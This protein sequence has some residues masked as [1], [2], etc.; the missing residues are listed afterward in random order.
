MPAD[1]SQKALAE[2]VSEAQETIDALGHGLMQLEAGGHEDPD[3][4]V[5]NGVFR[6][7]HTLKGLSSMSGVER[8]TRLA[9]ALEDLLDEVR[10][11]RRRLDRPALDLLLEAP[12][13]LSRIVAEEASG[14]APASTD[15]AARLTDRLRAGEA[16]PPARAADSLATVALGPEVLG[17]LTE[18]EEHRLR[19]NL[20]KGLGLH[21]VKVSFDLDGFDRELAALNGRLKRLGEVVSTLPS[22]DLRDPQ[23]IAFELL[24]ASKEPVDAIRR[25]A[26]PAAAVEAVPRV[27]AP[28]PAPRAD[29]P[30]RAGG[31]LS[32]A[33][34]A[35]SDDAASLRSASQAVRVDIHEL[36][37][38]MNAVGELVLVK[39]SLVALAERLRAEG[40]DP[41]AAAELQRINRTL[42]RR[43]EEL[44]AGILE[45]RMVPLEQVFDK[46]SRM[47]RKLAR[48]VGKEIDL[49]VSGGEVELDKLIVEDL[50]DP[51]M[52]LIRNAI[53][54]GIE[55]PERRAR[56]G[57]PPLGTVRLEAAPQGNKVRIVVEDDGGGIDEDR[58]R[59]VA[60]QRGLATAGDVG[61]L[62]RRELMNLIFVPGFST[63]RQVTSLSGRGVGMDVVKSNVAALSGIIDLH[64][65]R[66][67]GT[68][69][70]ITLPVT[71]AIVRALV[72]WVAGRTYA[73]PLNSVLEILE[74]RAAEVRTLST[75][76]VVTVRGATL[77]LVRLSTFFGLPGAGAPERLFVVVV[78]LAQ[79]RLG[80][81]VDAVVGQQDVVVKPLGSVLQGVRGIAGA[82]DLGS[83]RTVL[84]LD[85]GAIIEDVVSGEPREAAG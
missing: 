58:I 32:P 37:R 21:R 75:R 12:E 51:L 63:A 61:A 65:E 76:E 44:Q 38:L 8:L 52:H 13:V 25:E 68:R 31:A 67:R 70:E 46:L 17:I 77:P 23:A 69:F 18:Y 14:A 79:E 82:T 81:A 83:R 41:A 36:D 80:V 57:K 49:R 35:P 45:V 26:G 73:V 55:A 48:E 72:V 59:E 42:E 47:V 29:A 71:L 85:V 6:A 33:P 20:D 84:V 16:P 62:S 54:H 7:A 11:G 50:S 28:P 1:R 3:P 2:F 56:A 27:E 60:V 43:L 30:R 19:A 9:H 15:A 10:L 34:E 39:T 22:S 53:D 4:D 5:L 78:G 40:R 64:T 74:V 24:F 66:G